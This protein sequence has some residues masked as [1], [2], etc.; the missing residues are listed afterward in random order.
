MTNLGPFGVFLVELQPYS[1]GYGLQIKDNNSFEKFKTYT[2]H[3]F[4]FA[5]S[6]LIS[7]LVTSAEA[8]T[9][10]ACTKLC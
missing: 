10:A 9:A 3:R 7:F 4:C 5:E 2:L 1:L 8:P 6:K